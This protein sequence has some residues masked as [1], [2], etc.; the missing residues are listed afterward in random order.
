MKLDTP[1]WCGELRVCGGGRKAKYTKDTQG[2]VI[3]TKGDLARLRE[4]GNWI[5][6]KKKKTYLVTEEA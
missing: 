6:H 5:D 4:G 1:A 2:P 3:V